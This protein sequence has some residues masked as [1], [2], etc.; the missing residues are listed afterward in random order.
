MT[1][2]VLDKQLQALVELWPERAERLASARLAAFLGR[3]I[4]C[5]IDGVPAWTMR[6]EPDR[7][8]IEPPSHELA[9]ANIDL[10]V[11]DWNSVLDGRLGII[12]MVFAGRSQFPKHE[13]YILSKVSIVLQ[14][15][16]T[17]GK[18]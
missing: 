15:L 5:K 6:F 17:M 14:S 11:A 8:H 4:N 2:A 13:R 18:F 7:L 10:S 12:S 16:A 3:N 9:P 1:R